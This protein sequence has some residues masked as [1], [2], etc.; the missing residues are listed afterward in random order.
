MQITQGVSV[1]LAALRRNK[2]RSVL[3]TLGII[4]GIAAVVAVVSVGGGAEHLIL[5]EMERIGGAGMIV[6]FRKDHIRREDGSYRENKHPEYIEYEDLEFILE[7]CPSLK[8]ASGQSG[9]PNRVSHR[10]VNQSLQVHGVTP[11]FQEVNNWYVKSG[12][13]FTTE[14]MERREPICL[15]GSE[16]HK[17]FFQMD[18]PIGKEMKI[19]RERFTVIGVMEEKGNM[20][21]TEG[22]DHRVII[23]LLTMETRFIGQRKGWIVLFGQAES[24]EKVEQAVAEIKVAFRQLHGDEKYFDFFTAKEMI[25]QVGNVSRIVQVLL[26]AVASIALF[27]GGIGIMNIMLV[28]VTERTR[29]IGLRKSIGAKR[30]DILIQFLI[31]AI[32]LS[33]CG[34]LIGIF[35]GSGLA[36]GSGWVISKFL[37]KDASWPAIVSVQAAVIAFCVSACIGIFFGI[38]P[39]NKAASLTPT[40]A[41]RHV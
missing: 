15:I 36:T 28:S 40:E 12:R 24:Y 39:A 31:E 37:I 13:F 35:V 2:L 30:T 8:T 20:M 3:T 10:H 41:L 17:D 16:V 11:S 38:Y 21:A 25:K 34:G 27:V 22:W 18:D 5:I 9:M 33:I 1:G 32:V 29:E 6:C 23:P 19:G 7:T 26:G 14:E 4:I